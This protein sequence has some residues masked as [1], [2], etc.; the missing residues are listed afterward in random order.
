MLSS[1]PVTS[2]GFPRNRC[3]SLAQHSPSRSLSR[4][5]PWTTI[6]RAV[7][8]CS[9]HICLFSSMMTDT[10]TQNK[11]HMHNISHTDTH[12]PVLMFLH[13]SVCVGVCWY[14]CMYLER[15]GVQDTGAWEGW[16]CKTHSRT[17]TLIHPD[18]DPPY[19]TT[20]CKRVRARSLLVYG[21][22][23]PYL[24]YSHSTLS[25]HITSLCFVGVC[26]KKKPIFV[27]GYTTPT[28]HQ[29]SPISVTAPVPSPPA[30]A[31]RVFTFS[32]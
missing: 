4:A 15:A 1:F 30:P 28:L 20:A 12:V 6:V 18:E 29:I 3:P 25:P 21:C 22:L 26:H 14:A 23:E 17:H 10:P 2:T 11:L 13:A 31:L 7:T 16:D 19:W 5:V 8:L 24:S 32:L 27:N 9:I